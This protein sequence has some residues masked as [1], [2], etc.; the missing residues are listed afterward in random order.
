MET[1]RGE[2][3]V[4][5]TTDVLTH[6][7]LD[8][9]PQALAELNEAGTKPFVLF[10]DA[11]N[12][13]LVRRYNFTRRQHPVGAQSLLN[14]IVQERALLEPLRAAADSVI[15]TSNISTAELKHEIRERFLEAKGF[16]LRLVSFGFKRGAPRD[17][18]S[19]FD[20]RGLPNPYYDPQLAH[21]TAKEAA[22]QDYVFGGDQ[23]NMYEGIAQVVQTRAATAEGGSR[24]GYSIEI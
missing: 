8:A 5:I 4:V 11:N 17:V 2:A 20:V 10:L 19:I 24:R 18:D 3:N 13:V 16:T 21:L 6:A 14:D 15:D 1:V 9:V 23:T 12:D 7:Y 22:V